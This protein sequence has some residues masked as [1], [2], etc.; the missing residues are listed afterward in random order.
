MR[1]AWKKVAIVLVATFVVVLFAAVYPLRQL[2]QSHADL[3]KAKVELQQK[4]AER[5]ALEQRVALL[6]TPAEVER[7][8]RERFGYARPGEVP[9]VVVDDITPTSSP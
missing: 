9:Y 4:Q 8:A 5:A 1:Q 3:E 6:N 2:R 7:L